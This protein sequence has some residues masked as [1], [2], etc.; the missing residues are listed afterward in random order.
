MNKNK[1]G[2]WCELHGNL[3]FADEINLAKEVASICEVFDGQLILE[4]HDSIEGSEV[5]LWASD[6]TWIYLRRP[7]GVWKTRLPSEH[8]WSSVTIHVK[9]PGSRTYMSTVLGVESNASD[10]WRH[11]LNEYLQPS[12]IDNKHAIPAKWGIDATELGCPLVGP[13][14]AENGKLIFKAGAEFHEAPDLFYDQRW[15][16]GSVKSNPSRRVAFE[17]FD[18]PVILDSLQRGTLVVRF[19]GDFLMPM[20]V[21]V[22]HRAPT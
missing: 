11:R 14:I 22:Q 6:S 20:D 9:S 21:E 15:I 10:K 8:D 12:E 5:P 4:L 3:S 13:P 19:S 18:D 7:E 2:H 1:L 16:F 17:H